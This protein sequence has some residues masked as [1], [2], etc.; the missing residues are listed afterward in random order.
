MAS[1]AGCKF[2]SRAKSRVKA[3]HVFDCLPT[4]LSLALSLPCHSHDPSLSL[5]SLPSPPHTVRPLILSPVKIRTD[6]KQVLCPSENSVAPLNMMSSFLE[7]CV[8]QKGLTQLDGINL[9]WLQSQCMR[10][11]EELR[12]NRVDSMCS[13]L[14]VLVQKAPA[15]LTR[16]G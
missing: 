2:D 9:P 6:K 3:S 11:L 12:N 13:S 5:S 4:R 14:V 7:R 1:P 16:R 15:V 8:A 10:D